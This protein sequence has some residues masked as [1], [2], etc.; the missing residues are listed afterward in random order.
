M[1]QSIGMAE[2][3]VDVKGRT[4]NDLS[5]ESGGCRKEPFI[6][7]FMLLWVTDIN[8]SDIADYI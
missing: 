8:L 5:I 4:S 7:D 6:V 3:R 1:L 2:I